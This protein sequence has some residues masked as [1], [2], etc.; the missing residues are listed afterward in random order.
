MNKTLAIVFAVAALTFFAL[1]Q[2]DSFQTQD[3][4]RFGSPVGKERTVQITRND[5][6]GY[7]IFGGASMTASLYFISRIR[8]DDLRR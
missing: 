1:S 2:R 8:R 4:G 5:K 6:V 3:V 7:V